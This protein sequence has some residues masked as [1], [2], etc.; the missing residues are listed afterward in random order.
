M[1]EEKNTQ[2]IW[3]YRRKNGILT[4]AHRG[5]CGGNIIQNTCLAYENAIQHGADMIEVDVI[6][7]TDGYFYAYHDGQEKLVLNIDKDPREMSSSEIESYPCHNQLGI[8]VNQ[9]LERLDLVLERFKGRCFINI[10]RSWFFWKEIIEYLNKSEILD[11]IILK[12]PVQPELLETLQE[13]GPTIMY[14]PI[15]KTMEDW[16][17]VKQYDI[18]LIAAELIFETL[19]S[20]LIKPE[21]INKLHEEHI[22]TWVNAITLDDEI[23]LSALLDDNNAIANGYQEN[24]GKLVEL[25]FDIIQTDWPGLLT[26]FLKQLNQNN[27]N[28]GG[29]L[30]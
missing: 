24:W 14:M 19:D 26:G 27:S 23:V 25:G 2:V 18:N 3:E 10:D 8:A 13:L 20:P 11:Q 29:E 12:S 21:F 6:L 4:A 1:D 9:R 17:S 16:E 15:V 5:T 22:L 30:Q 28:E 7:S